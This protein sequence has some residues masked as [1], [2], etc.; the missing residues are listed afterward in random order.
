M[1]KNRDS[2]FT[3]IELMMAIAILGVILTMIYGALTSIMRA[4]NVIEDQR[5]VR[6]IANAVLTRLT[7]EM[8]L[9]YPG[10]PRLPPPDKLEE[11]FGSKDNLLGEK[12]TVGSGRPAD[13]IV[14]VALSA[15]Q[16]VPD[17]LT[18][19]GLVQ[20]SYSMQEDPEEKSADGKSVYVLVREEV[21]YL[22][23]YEDAYKQRM[24]FPLTNRIRS[25]QLRYLDLENDEWV[26]TWGNEKGMG[27]PAMIEFSFELESE[28]GARTW[29]TS[30]V[31]LR[32][33]F[34]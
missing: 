24:V 34:S 7:R 6:Q 33:S 20:I 29:Y 15:G 8:Q 2:A 1:T 31:P 30:A 28:Q 16:Y 27:L 17:G 13:H 32:R 10:I 22:R 21:P 9:A 26:S 25:F 18:H 19:G 23:P 12:E 14:F 4:K 3:L 5:E 11:R